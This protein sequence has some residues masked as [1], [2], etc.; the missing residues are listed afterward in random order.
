MTETGQ[1]ILTNYEDKLDNRPRQT[2][3]GNIFLDMLQEEEE[4]E[5]DEQNRDN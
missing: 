2:S 5:R 4:K 3:T 1:L